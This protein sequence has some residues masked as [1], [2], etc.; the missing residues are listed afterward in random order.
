MAARW[1][2]GDGSTKREQPAERLT[3]RDG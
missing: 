3:E 2:G 1:L